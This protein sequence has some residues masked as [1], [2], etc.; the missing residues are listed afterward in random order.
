MSVAIFRPRGTTANTTKFE[1]W[2][3][4]SK[5]T[6][7]IYYTFYFVTWRRKN[8]EN[9]DA[10]K[11][12]K[13]SLLLKHYLLM[14][15]TWMTDFSWQ[16]C[17]ACQVLNVGYEKCKVLLSSYEW[18]FCLEWLWNLPIFGIHSIIIMR[19]INVKVHFN[20]Y[21]NASIL[22][23]IKLHKVCKSYFLLFSV[24]LL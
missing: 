6:W 22:I 20:M 21:W 9:V 1:A 13:Y 18:S 2:C 17:L 7:R 24:F 14:N 23:C 15:E 4:P 11:M 10:K 5:A 19:Y 16:T 8:W 3:M 12:L